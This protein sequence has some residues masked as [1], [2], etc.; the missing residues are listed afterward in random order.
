M[1]DAPNLPISENLNTKN[2]NFICGVVEGFYGR[3]WTTEQRKELFQKMKK[4]GMDS[5]VY[6]PKDDYKHRA[7]WRELYTVEEA[8]HL[9]SLI[10]AA[11][12]QNIKF[13]YALS[14]GL[15][16]TYSNVKEI[17]ALKR[18]LE[19]VSQFGCD[20]F[21]LLFDDIEPEMSEADK[22]VFQSFAHAQV[23]VT[24][25]IYQHLGQPKF[26]LCPTQYCATRAVPN[27]TNSEYLN[28]LGSKLAQEIEIMWTG[29][30]VISRVL[31]KESI[32]E[33]TDVLRRPP[34]I[35]DN[36]H[37]ND[38]DQKR[39]FLGPYSGRS[40]DLIPKLRGVL[41]NPNCEYGANFVAIHTLA[42][43]SRCNVDGQRDLTL[44]DSVSA[45]IK[46]ETETED[47]MSGEDVPLTLSA[48]M[49]HPRQALRNA[50]TE[51]LPEF[52]RHKNAWGPIAKPQPA[53]AIAPVP[54]IPSINTCMSL[55]TSTTT[56]NTATTSVMVAT[57][58]VV[59]TTQ[60]QAL[61]EVSAN[62][63]LINPLPGPVM[64]S[65]VSPTKVICNEAIPNPITPAPIPV[66]VIAENE[67]PPP[68]ITILNG[69]SKDLDGK[70]ENDK[71]D[72]S[73]ESSLSPSEPMDC[74]STPN[75]SPAHNPKNA[76]SSDDVAMSE[77]SLSSG[78][79]SASSSL[80]LSDAM[81]VENPPQEIENERKQ[82]DQLTVEDLQLLCDLFYLPFEH[83]GQGL[84]ILQEF[85][86]LKSN[87]QVVINANRAAEN[88]DCKNAPEAQEWR[89]R[90]E[91]MNEMTVG[92]NRL[93]QRLS[94]C[95][96][97]ELLHDLH[98]YAWDIRGV[99]SLLNSYIKWLAGGHFP[100]SM[101]SYTQGTY[102]CT[103][104]QR[105]EFLF[106]VYFS[107]FCRYFSFLSSSTRRV[108]CR[109]LFFK[110]IVF[111]F[112]LGFSKGWKETFM[113]GDQEPWVFR[114]GLTADLQRLIP[115]DS[116]NDLF[117]YKAPDVPSCKVYTVRPYLAS[118]EDSVY[119]ICTR[120]CKDGLE[121][122]HPYPEKYKHLHADRIVGPYVAFHPE[123]C[124]VVQD[125]CEV[126]GYACAALDYKKFR[127]KQELAWI[128]EMCAKYGKLEDAEN[129][130]E[131]S[132]FA[133]EGIGYFHKF[134]DEPTLNN[135]SQSSSMVCSLLPSVLDQSV[136]KQLV[137][138]LLAALR[139]NGSFGVHVIVNA[140]DSYTHS[141][142]G[143]L[144]FSENTSQVIPGKI[145]M[146]RSF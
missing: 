27:V 4:W 43:W 28:T 85:N 36:L 80:P 38:Y 134:A 142:Y 105:V 126:V 136:G 50:I 6:A 15:D 66:K 25:D 5:Y 101:P 31:T 103:H 67:L 33:I 113:S 89:M 81:L 45:D 128:P 18:K 135:I 112:T 100:S 11:R 84:Q 94:M 63:S 57:T 96:N 102:T 65:L 68:N 88:T 93:L 143:K 110:C 32:Q 131:L 51:W 59:N 75:I 108:F 107:C 146:A 44:N 62:E 61:A 129:N 42:Q 78:T 120:T 117:V 97:R 83:G 98:S 86:W 39:V 139:A 92:I 60:L 10:T 41:T 121:D 34:V 30:K 145:V 48:N 58:P 64:N 106:L 104:H 2:G 76:D 125:E 17:L 124:I 1:A 72:V 73:N 116:G 12:E 137:T 35:W 115:V 9:T 40:P 70:A 99:I 54:I 26:L 140:A 91:K 55:T 23:S 132:K 22:E 130:S 127:V 114:G 19:Q 111:F 118:D 123:F 82:S 7:Y 79:G 69:S 49:Y 71:T 95:N 133:K 16:I 46:L 3:P 52:S 29:P 109:A 141:F 144:G 122:C 21:A 8:E 119:S 87:A 90:A 14:P 56:T 13:Y 53:V 37:A 24:N 77:V 138:C 47:G 20:A 74:N